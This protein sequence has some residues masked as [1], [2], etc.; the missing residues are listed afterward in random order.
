MKSFKEFLTELFD[1]VAPIRWTTRRSDRWE[2]Q[3]KVGKKKFEIIFDEGRSRGNWKVD[4]GSVNKSG[5]VDFE[6]TGEAGKDAILIYSTVFDTMKKFVKEVEP[7]KIEGGAFDSKA[8]DLYNKFAQRIKL[9]GYKLVQA[10]LGVA[11][12]ERK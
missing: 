7:N 8:A 2:A 10:M 1:K 6:L 9:P 3:F 4:F 11:K 5:G 12:W